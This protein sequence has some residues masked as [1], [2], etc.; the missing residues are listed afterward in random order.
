MAGYHALGIM[1]GTSCDGIDMATLTTDGHDSITFHHYA[2]AEFPAEVRIRLLE[3][4][5][6]AKVK[7]RE[8]LKEKKTQDTVRDY[9]TLIAN[10]IRDNFDVSLLDVIGFHGQT[11]LH[12]P[13]LGYTI[14]IGDGQLLAK[15]TN[16]Q[17]ICDF[18]RA[19]VMAGGQGAPLAPLY[20]RALLRQA[21]IEG[22]VGV[23]INIGGVANVT[24]YDKETDTIL[25][26][27][28]GMGNGLSDFLCQKFFGMPYD[29][30][31]FIAQTGNIDWGLIEKLCK[32]P[33]FAK[34]P[35]KSLDRNEF[36]IDIFQG[37]SSHDAV[38]TA[39]AFTAGTI[40]ISDRFYPKTPDFRIVAGGGV[41][42]KAIMGLIAQKS[43][44]PVFSSQH[45]GFHPC[46]IEAQCFAWLAVRALKN[47]PLSLPEITGAKYAIT[48]GVLCKPI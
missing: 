21:E 7:G 47:L 16:T 27:D 2:S 45:L 22:K 34:K 42:N 8:I 40:L 43:S 30:D 48:G 24:Y 11:I 31:G 19:D 44:S 1:T 9:T 6:E 10:V 17:V 20:H 33:F 38:A 18:R 46:A 25:G 36:S 35:P 29:K 12:Q 37:L 15:L 32:N 23:F 4:G 39:A 5:Q 13:H 26:W 14:Q 3:L 28:T 41:Y